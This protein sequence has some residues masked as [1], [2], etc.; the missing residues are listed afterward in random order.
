MKGLVDGM[1]GLGLKVG[2]Y[3]SP[4]PLT[5]GGCVGSYEHEALDAFTLNLLTNDKVLEVNQDPLGRQA[6]RVFKD[7]DREVWAKRMEDG[8]VA[9]GCSTAA[10]FP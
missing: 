9:P 10:S 4:G 3:S 8:S 7:G 1:H 2:I 5:C 6:A